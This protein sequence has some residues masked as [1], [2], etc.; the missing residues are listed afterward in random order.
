MHIQTIKGASLRIS[1]APNNT[2][3][4]QQVQQQKDVQKVFEYALQRFFPFECFLH[5]EQTKIG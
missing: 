3:N 4:K 5:D 1:K 2:N